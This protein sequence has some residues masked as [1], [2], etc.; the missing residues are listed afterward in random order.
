MQTSSPVLG[1]SIEL[2]GATVAL[3]TWRLRRM[4]GAEPLAKLWEEVP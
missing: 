1:A 2:V 4:G 3:P